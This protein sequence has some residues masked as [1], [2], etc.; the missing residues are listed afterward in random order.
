MIING[1]RNY[2]EQL[3]QLT[4][5]TWD[6]DLICKSDRDEL[7]KCGYAE[8]INGFNLI[9]ANGIIALS[10]LGIIRI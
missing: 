9:T 1:K 4:T 10:N 2:M 7:V 6:G 8:K 5:V 3:V